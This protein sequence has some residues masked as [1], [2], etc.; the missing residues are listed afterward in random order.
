MKAESTI[1]KQ[2]QQLCRISN[3]ADDADVRQ[4]AYHACNAL[5]WV[6]EKT[7]WSPVGLAAMRLVKLAKYKEAK[8]AATA[9]GRE[10]GLEL[11]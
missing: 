6:I 8:T 2:I 11:R 4:Q 3:T 10:H 9:A 5:R 7:N 1:R